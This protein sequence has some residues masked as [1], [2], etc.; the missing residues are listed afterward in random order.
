MRQNLMCIALAAQEEPEKKELPLPSLHHVKPINLPELNA[1]QNKY[2][3]T[4]SPE[5]W[6]SNQC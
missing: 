3:K 4:T 5:Y 1:C 2:Q 6:R